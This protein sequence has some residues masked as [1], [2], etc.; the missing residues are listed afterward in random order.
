MEGRNNRTLFDGVKDLRKLIK[1]KELLLVIGEG[2]S[3]LPR[4]ATIDQWWGH[5]DADNPQ[6]TREKISDL[7]NRYI[8]DNAPEAR[9]SRF[10]GAIR[11]LGKVPIIFTTNIDELL[12]HFLWKS[13]T[14]GDKITLEQVA[15][16][17]EVNNLDRQVIVKL[18]GDKSYSMFVTDES[19]KQ[20]E[21]LHQEEN[22][23]TA[24]LTNIFNSRNVLFLG[25]DTKHSLYKNFIQ[26][27]VTPSSKEHFCFLKS[28]KNEIE[29]E[30]QLTTLMADMELWEFV[31]HLKSGDVIREISEI[32]P[33]EIR[34]ISFLPTQRENYLTQQLLLEKTATEIHFHTTKVTNALTTLE[35][36]EKESKPSLE[37]IFRN[38]PFG[39]SQEKQIEAAMDAMKGRRRNLLNVIELGKTPVVATFLYQ[40]VVEELEHQPDKDKRCMALRKYAEVIL[41]SKS[42]LKTKNSLELVIV[43]AEIGTEAYKRLKDDTF[44]YIKLKGGVN[45]AICYADTATTSSKKVT[46]HLIVINGEEVAKRRNTYDTSVSVGWDSDNSLLRL[47]TLV[48]KCDNV[49]HVLE[50]AV[51]EK[52]LSLHDVQI[53]SSSDEYDT[54]SMKLLGKGSFGEVYKVTDREGK[55]FALKML[56]ELQGEQQDIIEAF[57]KEAK[58]LDIYK[59]I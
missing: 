57:K 31:L 52:L 13:G 41:Q 22:R 26:R 7:E 42:V 30:G 46:T 53:L 39:E 44:A 50:D 6:L 24:K 4:A 1:E 55:V 20:F 14:D 28:N 8:R 45:E 2:E 16:L 32:T 47:L 25:C 12:E 36:L 51:R 23:L 40:A 11:M 3:A 19:R 59:L 15:R 18:F 56:K 21:L 34:E 58:S 10:H 5:V 33:G 48:I 9:Q 38:D 35:L 37:R 49:E 17:P 54:K 43:D 27:F 29:Q